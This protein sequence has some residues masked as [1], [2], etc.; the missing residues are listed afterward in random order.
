MQRLANALSAK[1]EDGNIRAA[2]RIVCSE[3][4]PAQKT[5]SVY[6]QLVDKH[7]APPLDRGS[8][9]D[10]QPTVAVEMTKEEVIREVRS[11]SARISRRP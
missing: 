6:A 2:I 3:D 9:P 1:I 4:K 11:F 5:D 8:V 10:P 7:L